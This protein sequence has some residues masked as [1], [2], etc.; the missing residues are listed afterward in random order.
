MP[1]LLVRSVRQQLIERPER[2]DQSRRHR[3]SDAHLSRPPA[4]VVV[5]EV[6]SARGLK[7]LDFL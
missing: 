2:I 6:E 4:E 1:S 5:G 3:G 7:I